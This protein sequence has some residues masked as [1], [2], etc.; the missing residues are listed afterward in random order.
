[1]SK[2]GTVDFF[3][4]IF[5]DTGVEKFSPDTFKIFVRDPCG[6]GAFQ[7]IFPPD[8]GTCFRRRICLFPAVVSVIAVEDQKFFV[9]DFLS[10]GSV[11][12]GNNIIFL[13]RYFK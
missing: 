12:A 9:Q 4:R 1:M 3:C 5:R 7:V 10:F 8:K 2:Q 13:K 6:Q 11:S